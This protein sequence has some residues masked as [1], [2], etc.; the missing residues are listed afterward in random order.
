MK[1]TNETEFSGARLELIR[2]ALGWTQADL[3]KAADVSRERIRQIEAGSYPSMRLLQRLGRVLRIDVR[4]LFV[5]KE[6]R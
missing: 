2:T 4:Q 1:T 5:P 6:D 3:A